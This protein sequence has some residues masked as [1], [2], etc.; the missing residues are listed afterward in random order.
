[1]KII[2]RKSVTMLISLCLIL[3]IACNANS[4]ST[5]TTENDSTEDMQL[6]QSAYFDNYS[7]LKNI[8]THLIKE[9]KAN[10]YLE[11]NS[12]P[13]VQEVSDG[14]II[15]VMETDYSA[16][17]TSD[18]KKQ[19]YKNPTLYK[20]DKDG[21]LIW[22]QVYNHSISHS[23]MTNLATYDDGRILFSISRNPRVSMSSPDNNKA[24][25]VQCDQDGNEIWKHSYDDYYGSLFNFLFITKDKEIITVGTW[26]DSEKKQT[27]GKPSSDIV[28]TYLDEAGRIIK[29][30]GYGGEKAE[31]CDSAIYD[32]DIGVVFTGW[33]LSEAGDFVKQPRDIDLSDYIACIDESLNLRWVKNPNDYERYN[34]EQILIKDNKVYAVGTVNDPEAYQKNVLE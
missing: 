8:N 32:P 24:Y 12:V 30:K 3:L 10:I 9:I 4:K 14:Y 23:N 20:I 28:V 7:I 11:D 2:L 18:E 33:T 6:Q 22:K 16:E 17:V 26:Y 1:M 5:N 34:Y 15:G 13:L 19:F 31:F 29:Q 25:L 27:L 21:N